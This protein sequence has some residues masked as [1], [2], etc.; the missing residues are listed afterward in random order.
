MIG[1][2]VHDTLIHISTLSWSDRLWFERC[3]VVG[4]TI[5]APHPN[6]SLGIRQIRPTGA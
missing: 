5:V 2:P 4:N 1:M 3:E 6:E